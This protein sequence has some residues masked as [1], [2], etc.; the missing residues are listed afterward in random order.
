MRIAMYA[1][2]LATGVILPLVAKKTRVRKAA[3]NVMAKGMEVTEDAKSKVCSIKEE[4]QDIYAEAKQ[5]Q[6]E[7]EMEKCKETMEDEK[8]VV[9]QSAASE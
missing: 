5:K 9:Q 7:K 6:Q 2:G 8:E 1:I 3:V 4:A